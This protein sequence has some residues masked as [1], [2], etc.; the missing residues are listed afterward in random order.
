MRVWSGCLDASKMLRE[1]YVF[2]RNPDGSSKQ[3]E[4]ITAK[5]RKDAFAQIATK[6]HDSTYEEGSGPAL[7]GS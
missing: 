7:F 4:P 1:K 3:E 6:V 5:M 2:E